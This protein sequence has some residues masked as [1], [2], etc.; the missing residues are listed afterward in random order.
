MAQLGDFL[1]LETIKTT[2]FI[3]EIFKN[4]N[5]VKTFQNFCQMQNILNK[6]IELVMASAITLTYNEIKYIK[7]IK[8]LQNRGILLRGTTE[9][10][11]VTKE[12][13]LVIFLIY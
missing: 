12:N 5:Q 7:I 4:K 8:S 3:G 11:I 2:R 9:R 13:S 6:N 10:L 1:L